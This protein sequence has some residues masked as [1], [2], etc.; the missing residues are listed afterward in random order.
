[1][2]KIWKYKCPECHRESGAYYSPSVMVICPGCQIIMTE[3]KK[4][5]E[6]DTRR[7]SK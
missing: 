4:E 5:K 2:T 6:S 7:K 1:M 3:I